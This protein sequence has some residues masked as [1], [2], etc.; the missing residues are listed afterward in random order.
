MDIWVP[1]SCS[2][3]LAWA[4]ARAGHPAQAWAQAGHREQAQGT[5]ISI[6]IQKYPWMHLG[7]RGVKPQNLSAYLC[8]SR[9][10]RIVCPGKNNPS[11][12]SLSAY[13][14][15]SR[16]IWGSLFA[17]PCFFSRNM[18]QSICVPPFFSRNMVWRWLAC[19]GPLPP[20]G[21]SESQPRNVRPRDAK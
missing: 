3:W 6:D 2:R 13:P 20:L 7:F 17:Y 1:W 15:F 12:L 14:R 21:N 19:M 8:F 18:A 16:E 10:I 4:R 5:Q 9:E 11:R